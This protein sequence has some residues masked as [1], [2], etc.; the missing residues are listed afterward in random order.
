MEID[1][2]KYVLKEQRVIT[3]HENG[4]AITHTVLIFFPG[5]MKMPAAAA[6]LRFMADDIDAFCET[7]KK[8]TLDVQNVV[9]AAESAGPMSD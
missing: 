1:P 8:A 2:A 4:P 5:E 6:A 9:S 3:R 7:V